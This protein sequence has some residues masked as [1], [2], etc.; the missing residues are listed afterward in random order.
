MFF[1]E[2]RY[3][4]EEVFN[5][6]G[7]EYLTKNDARGKHQTN[8]IVDGFDV[9]P[10][11]LR[12]MTF[13]QKGTKCI[14]CGREGTY[15]KLCVDETINRR[16]FNLYADD[17][18]LMTKDHIM[19]KSKGGNNTVENLQTMCTICNKEKGNKVP[20]GCPE[21][22]KKVDNNQYIWCGSKKYK[23]IWQAANAIAHGDK[24]LI[25]KVKKKIRSSIKDGTLYCGVVWRYGKE[26]EV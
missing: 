13:Y 9:Y 2:K 6:I 10:I 25:P 18:T 21:D 14:C 23:S 22:L 3:G 24:L 26:I 7:E 15:F 16:H 12:Y 19:P 1:E 4:I 5:I 17:G 20:D 8:I 11:S